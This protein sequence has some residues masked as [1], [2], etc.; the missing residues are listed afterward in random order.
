MSKLYKS[1]QCV[2]ADPCRL[3]PA[4]VEAFFINDD[5]KEETGADPAMGMDEPKDGAGSTDPLEE[6]AVSAQAAM[7]LE[8]ASAVEMIAA[9]KSAEGAN[10]AET[11]EKKLEGGT[12]EPELEKLFDVAGH[13]RSL[14][15]AG[16]QKIGK[17]TGKKAFMPENQ[18]FAVETPSEGKK[19]VPRTFSPPKYH[20]GDGASV[21]AKD[22]G[23]SNPEIRV[24]AET[25][26]AIERAK[27][28]PEAR[29]ET[30]QPVENAKNQAESLLNQAQLQIKQRLEGAGQQA[31]AILS[32]AQQQ[33][34][35]ITFKASQQ[36]QA[37]LQDAERQAES[38]VESARQKVLL[39]IENAKKEA[40]KITEAARQEAA[41][42]TAAAQKEAGDLRKAAVEESTHLKNQARQEGFET[43]RREAA[44]Q[45]RQELEQ[46]LAAAFAL[47]NQAEE[48]RLKRISSSEPEL[49]K[50][51]VAIAEKIIGAELELNPTAMLEITREALTRAQVSN[52]IVIRV[53]QA[54]L[55]VFMEHSAVLQK[56][57]TEPKMIRIEEDPG[58]A[59]GNC[60]IETE[61]GNIDPRI[62]SQLE[63]IWAELLKAG[64]I[65]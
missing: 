19:G 48:E 9:S 35:Q 57:F 31:G 42:L 7:P 61:H 24:E 56:A 37:M 38:L 3:E 39:L 2:E 23:E 46:N 40:E 65:S 45:I 15:E 25:E 33:A 10:E 43:G 20:T 12:P 54:D 36:A 6:T 47:L 55:K 34:G 16:Q 59:P 11:V 17:E 27:I 41:R 63:M 26:A 4:D 53:N 18:D 44:A 64:A 49:L 62:K 22:H 32:G 51:A 5:F 21:K 58:V 13:I 1:E 52:N 29:Q 60:F 50:L 28:F 8:A 14:L 30:G